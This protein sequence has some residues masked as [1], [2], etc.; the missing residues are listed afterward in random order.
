[1]RTTI[2]NG[3]GKVCR[4]LSL[5]TQCFLKPRTAKADTLKSIT[6]GQ[7]LPVFKAVAYSAAI[8]LNVADGS[9]VFRIANLP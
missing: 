6:F 2:F 4:S 8:R 5:T 3:C 9:G 7:R 1:M